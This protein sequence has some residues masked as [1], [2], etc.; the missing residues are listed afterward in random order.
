MSAHN[1][2]TF[3]PYDP[4]EA[5]GN[6]SPTAP[7]PR[8]DKMG[9]C[10]TFG[11]VLMA[12]VAVVVATK[13]GPHA[14]KFFAQMFGA[15]TE[16]AAAAALV[17]K[18]TPVAEALTATGATALGTAG[19]AGV[20]V[21]GA[22]SAAAGSVASQ[23]A[24]IATG[25][26]EK[27]SWNAVA[28][29]ALGAGIGAGLGVTG[30]GG[31]G[32]PGAAARGALG[33]VITQGVG[34][35]LGLQKGF[36]WAA[37]AASAVGAG[38]GERLQQAGAALETQITAASIANAATRSLIDGSDF[39]D[40]MLA[41]LPD[42]IGAMLGNALVGA[43]DSVGGN[44]REPI[45]IDAAPLEDLPPY[46]PVPLQP[47]IDLSSLPRVNPT[48]AEKL[49]DKRD[50]Q[51]ETR[52][53]QAAARRQALAQAV[54]VAGRGGAIAVALWPYDLGGSDRDVITLSGIEDFRLTKHPHDY[55]WD[56]EQWVGG[57]SDEELMGRG[58][59]VRTRG[60]YVHR[61]GALVLDETTV[62]ARIA[63]RLPNTIMLNEREGRD[64][65]RRGFGVSVENDD[66][67]QIL[68]EGIGQGWD[69]DRI[70]REI[71]AHRSSFG[72][73][74]SLSGGRSVWDL[75]WAARG[76][77]LETRVLGT[78]AD[79]P[80]R[81]PPW[82]KRVDEFNHATG[83]AVSVKSINLNAPSYHDINQLDRQLTNH[84]NSVFEFDGWLQPST[85]YEIRPG[86]IRSRELIIVVPNAGT[87]AQQ[88]AMARA[89]QYGADNGVAV[90]YREERE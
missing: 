30:I 39:G 4:L 74:T 38:I 82:Y 43:W 64:G 24:G 5:L 80:L 9:K 40:N 75:G 52:A 32:W 55:M 46:T 79:N 28:L 47:L 71:A 85:G 3:K 53:A 84:V 90:R 69:S 27:F 76:I 10:A 89:V 48:T 26:Q 41:A 66:E 49:G 13:L 72:A 25:V 62:S 77:E 86:V 56:V 59:W 54:R 22:A 6:T 33:S 19:T 58:H 60:R 14:A 83:H 50:V 20:V 63:E 37:V 36:S 65:L 44:E 87:T 88:A 2:N 23:A 1:A 67:R 16:A 70:N 61:D 21:G 57:R 68:N 81:T 15:S 73:A 29:A 17:A 45:T 42:M 12:V 78:Y 18:G 51:A 11:M 7:N 31:A 35:A 34:D 8:P